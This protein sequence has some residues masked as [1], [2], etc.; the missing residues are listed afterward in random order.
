LLNL[1]R[2]CSNQETWGGRG[3][4]REMPC[5]LVIFAAKPSRLK[6]S[7]ATRCLRTFSL[8]NFVSIFEP[9]RAGW[10]V[11]WA[12]RVMPQCMGGFL[13]FALS[14]RLNTDGFEDSVRFISN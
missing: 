2:D 10:V 9:A 13:I 7:H 8:L 6:L 11:T 1:E 14:G 4:P 12:R 3:L 5:T